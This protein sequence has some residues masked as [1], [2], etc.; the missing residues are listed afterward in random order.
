MKESAQGSVMS[1][2]WVSVFF[3]IQKDPAY[4]GSVGGS[5]VGV[6][7]IC[8]YVCLCVLVMWEIYCVAEEDCCL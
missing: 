1:G 5:G 7:T 3:S 6:Y 8:V 2:S 4:S